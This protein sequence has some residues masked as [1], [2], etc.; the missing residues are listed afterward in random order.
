M[1]LNARALSPCLLSNLLLYILSGVH[2]PA[3]GL[4]KE[5]HTGC[6]ACIRPFSS[7]ALTARCTPQFLRVQ[8]KV[9]SREGGTLTCVVLSQNRCLRAPLESLKLRSTLFFGGSSKSNSSA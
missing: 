2:P 1:P 3:L 8:H 5:A 6:R 7:T 9:S 4:R